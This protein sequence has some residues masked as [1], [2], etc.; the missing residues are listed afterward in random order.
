MKIRAISSRIS[1]QPT[2]SVVHNFEKDL[3]SASKILNRTGTNP[4]T[5]HYSQ[6][7][8]DVRFDYQDPS[9]L[10]IYNPTIELKGTLNIRPNSNL[11]FTNIIGD[12][13]LT[14][15]TF[16][17]PYS[18][19]KIK[20]EVNNFRRINLKNLPDTKR[21]LVPERNKEDKDEIFLRSKSFINL[22]KPNIITSD[23][24]KSVL[25]NENTDT[26]CNNKDKNIYRGK[27]IITC[28]KKSNVFDNKAENNLNECLQ[29]KKQK[30][31]NNY[32]KYNTTTQIANLPGGIK[33]NNTEIK[34]DEDFKKFSKKPAFDKSCQAKL[35]MDFDSKISCLRSATPVNYIKL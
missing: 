5:I 10:Q 18:I 30:L 16:T 7:K 4:R 32:S 6:P 20:P 35:K 28:N 19:V 31:Y 17:E 2:K 15:K 21:T 8:R 9:M 27:K 29:H 12:T 33:R 3:S 23:N 24:L 26:S 1:T 25:A 11:R 22:K 34:D 13:S 14:N